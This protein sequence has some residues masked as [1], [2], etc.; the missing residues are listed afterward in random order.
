[1][2]VGAEGT[3]TVARPCQE[4]GRAAR[5]IGFGEGQNLAENDISEYFPAEP[6]FLPLTSSLWSCY[7]AAFPK[8]SGVKNKDVQGL[9]PL[10]VSI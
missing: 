5:G 6:R 10:Q 2:G 3:Q 7:T 8:N 9:P 4:E 1:M